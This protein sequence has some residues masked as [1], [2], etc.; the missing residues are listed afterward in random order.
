MAK[1]KYLKYDDYY[2]GDGNLKIDAARGFLQTELPRVVDKF[3]ARMRD[4]D[5]IQEKIEDDDT[6]VVVIWNGL[7]LS[8]LGSNVMMG[9]QSIEALWQGA[10]ISEGKSLEDAR[11]QNARKGIQQTKEHLQ[12]FMD[13]LD[14]ADHEIEEGSDP[15]KAMHSAMHKHLFDDDEK[16]EEEEEEQET[17]ADAESDEEPFTDDDIEKGIDD[18][19]KDLGDDDEEEGQPF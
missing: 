12:K 9:L 4:L 18:L 14:E 16:A 15:G 3:A 1:D 13:A 19:F 2:D 5:R 10:K 7:V 6:V 17:P 8:Q 11:S